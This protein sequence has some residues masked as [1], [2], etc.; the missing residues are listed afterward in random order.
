[1]IREKAINA[2]KNCKV[3]VETPNKSAGAQN[4]LFSLGFAWKSGDTKPQNT[5]APFLMVHDGVI[6]WSNDIE[7]YNDEDLPI[8]NVDDI[9]GSYMSRKA[10]KRINSF[11]NGQILYSE[12]QDCILVYRGTNPEGAIL[13]DTYMYLGGNRLADFGGEVKIGNG[14]TKD[15]VPATEEQRARLLNAINGILEQI[16]ER[17]KKLKDIQD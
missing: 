16:K 2:F 8:V 9:I 15:Y 7:D 17:V 11:Q 5:N 6:T 12:K 14:Y 13:S 10:R 4:V 3:F 1:M